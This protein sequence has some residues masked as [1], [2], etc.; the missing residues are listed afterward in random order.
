MFIAQELFITGLRLAGKIQLLNSV[1]ILKRKENLSSLS[2]PE[3][4]VKSYLVLELHPVAE[5]DL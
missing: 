1:L 3:H 5:P 2:F 4:E